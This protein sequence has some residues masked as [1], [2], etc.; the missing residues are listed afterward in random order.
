MSAAQACFRSRLFVLLRIFLLTLI[1]LMAWAFCLIHALIDDLF[2]RRRIAG[3][4]PKRM[5]SG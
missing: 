1:G 2:L 4:R 3:I 5:C